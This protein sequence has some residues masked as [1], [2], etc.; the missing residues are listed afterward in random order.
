MTT[1]DKINEIRIERYWAMP[2]AW[3]FS[4]KPIKSLLN[5]EVTKGKWCD[6]YCGMNG[7]N[8]AEVTNDLAQGGE[9][10]YRAN[11]QEI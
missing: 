11:E 9:V 6:P 4:I 8:Y 10:F 5:E 2:N 7:K 3:T 1:Q